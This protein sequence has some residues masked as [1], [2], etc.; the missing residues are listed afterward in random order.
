MCVKHNEGCEEWTLYHDSYSEQQILL[1]IH[2][3][4]NAA[5]L[6]EVLFSESPLKYSNNISNV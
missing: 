6:T 3:D 5:N 2:I 4:L 1:Q